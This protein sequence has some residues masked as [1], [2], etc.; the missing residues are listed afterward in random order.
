V[1]ESMLPAAFRSHAVEASWLRATAWRY[2]S[3]GGQLALYELLLPAAFLEVFLRRRP[4][5]AAIRLVERRR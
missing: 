3:S 4:E 5:A 1:H 2:Q